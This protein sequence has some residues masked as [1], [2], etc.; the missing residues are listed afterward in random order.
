M[1]VV[2]DI[3]NLQHEGNLHSETHAD[4]SGVPS[5]R[6]LCLRPGVNANFLIMSI[7]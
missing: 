3:G 1:A 5:I 4:N 6:Q 2:F 7:D